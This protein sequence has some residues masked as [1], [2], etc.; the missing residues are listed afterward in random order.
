M[1]STGHGQAVQLAEDSLGSRFETAP[2]ALNLLRLRLAIEVV[3][4]HSYVL[5]GGTWL[6]DSVARIVG[7]VAVDSFFAISGFLV[8]RSWHRRR[9]IAAYASARVRR[10]APGLWVCLLLTAFAIAPAAAVASGTTAPTFSAPQLTMSTV[11]TVNGTTPAGRLARAP[12][13]M[14][15]DRFTATS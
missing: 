7:D 12:A 6:P 11:R 14:R 9:G 2:N 8:C 3:V 13:A 4:W 5:L 10:I 1:L 15:A